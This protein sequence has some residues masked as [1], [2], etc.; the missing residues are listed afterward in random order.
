MKPLY[1][2]YE[3]EKPAGVYAMGYCGYLFFDPIGD[4]KYT[5]DFVVCFEYPCST[6]PAGVARSNYRRHNVTY[7]ASGRP[8][9]W[10]DHARVYLEDVM[11]TNY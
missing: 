11:R 4:D 10:R 9:V 2:R 5:C 6:A 3:N 8:L 1:K 7:G